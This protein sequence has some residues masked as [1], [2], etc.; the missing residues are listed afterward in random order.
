MLAGSQ[1]M[2][3]ATNSVDNP[4]HSTGLKGEDDDDIAA[5]AAQLVDISAES[6]SVRANRSALVPLLS[7]SHQDFLTYLPSALLWSRRRP[8]PPCDRCVT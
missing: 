7:H 1:Y 5:Q 8:L 3:S 6:K 4:S 2:D